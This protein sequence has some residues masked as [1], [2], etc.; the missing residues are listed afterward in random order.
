MWRHCRD[1]TDRARCARRDEA[2]PKLPVACTQGPRGGL[3]TGVRASSGSSI[4]LAS[5]LSPALHTPSRARDSNNLRH[6]SLCEHAAA[7]LY[8]P[9]PSPSVLY[10]AA[11]VRCGR[12]HRIQQRPSCLSKCNE[13]S[14]HIRTAWFKI[15]A[16]FKQRWDPRQSFGGFVNTLNQTER[17]N[18]KDL[19]LQKHSYGGMQE[20]SFPSFVVWVSRFSYGRK[21]HGS[22]VS[23]AD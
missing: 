21:W 12:Q 11:K 23:L 1:N 9:L 6:Y 19:A 14:I 5:M 7:T 18:F 13:R 3:L 8:E 22:T 20:L 2:W 16:Y 10:C 17:H 15:A 4:L